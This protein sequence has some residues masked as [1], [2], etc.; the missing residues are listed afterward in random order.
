MKQLITLSLLVLASCS[1]EAAPSSPYAR[2]IIRDK[3]GD[4][5]LADVTGTWSYNRKELF[6]DASGENGELFTVHL[7]NVGDTGMITNPDIKMISYSDGA[8]FYPQCIIGGQIK[9]S[10]CSQNNINCSFSIMLQDNTAPE[11]KL[12]VEGVFGIRNA[13]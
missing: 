10:G 1:R 9:I 8:D 11:A 6:L 13:D 4:M 5:I 2:I 12:M 7:T 3:E